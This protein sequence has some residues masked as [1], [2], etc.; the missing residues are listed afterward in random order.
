MN[1]KHTWIWI[2]VAAVLGGVILISEQFRRKPEAG[3]ILVL[4]GFK[5]GTVTSVQV[6]PAG[7]LEIR[8]ER[9]NAA[10]QLTKPISYPAQETS[11][12]T[13]LA[14]LEQ[15]TAS[16][17]ISATEWRRYT[18]ADV[19]FG[20]A[21]PQA[22]IAIHSR[23]TR[24]QILLGART[25]PGDQVYLQV[26]GVE[27]AYVIDAEFLKVIPHKADN[28]RDTGLV[29]SGDL[30]V[31]RLLIRHA[32]TVI[33]LQRAAT[34]LP[35]SMVRPVRARADNAR[36]IGLLDGLR[37][38]RVIEFISDD[39]KTDLEPLGLQPAELELSLERGTNVVT[40]LQF[41]K[42]PTNHPAQVFARRPNQVTVVTVPKDPL[43]PWRAPQ[44]DFRE[45]QL[46]TLVQPVDK[47]EV[48]G[49][50]NFTLQRDATNNWR[51]VGQDLPVDAGLV[52]E[53]LNTL[54]T[55]QIAQ[56]IEPITEPDLPTYG[57]APPLRHISLQAAVTNAAGVATNSAIV[58][59]A[60]G[61]TNANRIH[62]RRTDENP[63]YAIDLAGFQ[64]LPTAAWQLR[65]RRIWRFSTNDVVRLTIR[66]QGKV[67]QLVREEANSWVLAPGSQGIINQFAI[68]ETTHRFGELAATL[69]VERGSPD[70]ARYGMGTNG[71]SLEFELKN[72]GKRTVEIGHLSPAH[73]PYA[74]TQL[75]GE[76][77][78]FE[79]PLG[80]YY[81]M[82]SHLTIPSEVP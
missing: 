19:E 22:S 76:T 53:F 66:Q 72:G 7:A 79:L 18:N 77:W 63:V 42:S 81:L 25:A 11:V 15:L 36:V 21:A 56:F 13:L 55:L 9:T 59:L 68:E 69:W 46:V 78:I 28:W 47:I 62:V 80:L 33:E 67:R 31:D 32:A 73:Y 60:F 74:A 45:R 57:L 40:R 44:N 43:L 75:D 29:A 37:K 24:R 30:G 65:E 82:S 8:V 50:D 51:A 17:Q 23:D 20:F 10:W 2:M 3:P 34:N 54:G 6:R 49:P 39:P 16:A 52:D 26:V 64:Q 48:R 61:N 14:T 1:P 38:L 4:P 35:W 58:E 12:D 5:A 41:G 70:L 27:G 71:Y